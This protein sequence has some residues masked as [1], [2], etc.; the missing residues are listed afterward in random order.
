V[1]RE[2]SID[3]VA[4]K[5]AQIV[6]DFAKSRGWKMGD[7]HLFL[8]YRDDILFMNLLV[9]AKDLNGCDERRKTEIYY[10]LWDAIN[11]G[12]KSELN[13]I[14]SLGLVMRGSDEFD[15]MPPS[16][17]RP[18]EIEIDDRLINGGVSWT[19]SLGALAH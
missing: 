12:A 15:S 2:A 16:R 18:Y 3:Q 5:I 1:A 7:Y 11:A 6:H 19:E 13:L 9:I 4:L 17:L 14:N 10:D 8:K